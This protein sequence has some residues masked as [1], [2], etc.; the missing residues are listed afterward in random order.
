MLHQPR[1]EC[2]SC[3]PSPLRR[4]GV[5]KWTGRRVARWRLAHQDEALPLERGQHNLGRDLGGQLVP[6]AGV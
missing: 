1:P 5:T 6:V 4:S 2:L 3:P